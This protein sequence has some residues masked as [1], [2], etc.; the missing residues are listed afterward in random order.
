MRVV[1]YESRIREVKKRR[2]KE[3]RCDE[4]LKTTEEESTFLPY[5]GL[6]EELKH[7]KINRYNSLCNLPEVLT[8]PDIK[9]IVLEG[10]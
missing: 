10:F 8:I 7:P 3:D 1:Y 2:K 6:H 5:T 4:R 9:E